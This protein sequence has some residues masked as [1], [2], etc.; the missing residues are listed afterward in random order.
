MLVL[1]LWDC[2][3]SIDADEDEL[4]DVESEVLVELV[5]TAAFGGL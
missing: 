4:S 3:M 2:D 5:V 1:L